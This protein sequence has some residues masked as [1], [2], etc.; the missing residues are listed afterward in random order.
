M[1][2]NLDVFVNGETVQVSIYVILKIGGKMQGKWSQIF[3]AGKKR[4][5]NIYS[6]TLHAPRW[7]KK[8]R[9]K[10]KGVVSACL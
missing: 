6:D 8:D 1:Q 5:S 2:I 3:T 7:R 10:M 9:K 4:S